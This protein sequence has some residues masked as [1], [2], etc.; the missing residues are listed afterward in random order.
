MQNSPILVSNWSG[1]LG[2]GND[3]HLQA[4]SRGALL[5]DNDKQTDQNWGRTYN[6]SNPNFDWFLINLG[7]NNL[8]KIIYNVQKMQ[9]HDFNAQLGINLAKFPKP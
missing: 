1:N 6:S 9:T 4:T 2:G 7:L 5:V 3:D 8:F